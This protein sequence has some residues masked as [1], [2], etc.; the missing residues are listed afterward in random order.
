MRNVM[1]SWFLA[2]AVWRILGGGAM[3][4]EIRVFSGGAP[5]EV[6]RALGPEFESAT[7]HRLAFTFQLVTGLQKRLAAGEKADAIL[8]PVQLFAAVEKT[9]PLRPEGRVT[10]AR[11]GLAVIMRA[12]AKPPD[13]STPE[14]VG[15]TLV[16]ARSL[17]WSDP[18]T[19]TGAHLERM[20]AELGIG[21]EVKRKLVVKA[22]IDGGAE[23]V[24]SGAAE[25]GFYLLTEVKNAKGVAVAGMLP[26]VL[27][28][29][30]LYGA[31]VPA[32]SA[33]PE[34]AL[35]FVRFISDPSRRERWKDAGFELMGGP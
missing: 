15:K 34:A 14:A 19:P 16:E 11:V 27:Q 10:I 13:L 7:G 35:A 32:D 9:V 30:I 1:R 18:T 17:A 28:N 23:L 8:L 5:Q 12:G 4:A 25:L 21:E 22:A 3:G 31:A 29:Y 33:A 6:L 2:A 26:P 24:A 20:I